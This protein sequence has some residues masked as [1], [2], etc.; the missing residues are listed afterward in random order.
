MSRVELARYILLYSLNDIERF[1][2]TYL[3]DSGDDLSSDLRFTQLRAVSSSHS[4]LVL[5][6]FCLRHFI[7]SIRKLLEYGNSTI[8]TK[9]AVN[10]L[11]R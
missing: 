7:L 11:V 10:E 1:Q 4:I 8:A 6:D 9:S 2:V 5:L 3:P